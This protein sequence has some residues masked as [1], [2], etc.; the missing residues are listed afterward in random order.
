MKRL[1]EAEIQVRIVPTHLRWPERGTAI[2]WTR[3]HECVDALQDFVRDVDLG[4]LKAEQDRELSAGAIARR[5]AEICDQAMIKLANF[6]AFHI[7]EKTLSE[8][9]VAL[10]RLRNRDADQVQLLQKF[11]QALRDLQEG[12]EATRRMG[13]K[14]CKMREGISV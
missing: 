2:A 3:A 5:R 8:N 6:P 12:V 13:R 4:C 9:I 14:R 7:A 11:K 10:E 1:T